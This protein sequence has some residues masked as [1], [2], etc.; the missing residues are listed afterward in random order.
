[1][2]ASE[3]A[4]EDYRSANNLMVSQGVTLNTSTVTGQIPQIGSVSPLKVTPSNARFFQIGCTGLNC[5][6]LTP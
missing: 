5:N 6:A 2:V 1:M 3:K 4:V